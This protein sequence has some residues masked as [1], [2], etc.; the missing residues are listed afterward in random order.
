[1][2]AATY[3]NT[4][5]YRDL[6]GIKAYGKVV[7]VYDGDTFWI[8][9]D[10]ANLDVNPLTHVPRNPPCIKRVNVRLA[11]VDCHEIKGGTPETKQLA[12]NER[13][14]VRNCI[15]NKVVYLEFTGLCNFKRCL[16]RVIF[17]GCDLSN[18]LL[19]RG[20]AK[21]YVKKN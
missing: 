4:K 7:S 15:L 16:A 21:V 20:Y 9:I 18:D 17:D 6:D 14:Y 1:M 3:K 13:D 19:N 2:L 10:F 5:D 12:R 11:G 8:A